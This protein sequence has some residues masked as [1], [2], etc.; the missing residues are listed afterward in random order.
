MKSV[1]KKR[2][3]WSQ[4]E[5][6]CVGKMLR[7]DVL[8][9][10]EKGIKRLLV[11]F[12]FQLCAA[13]HHSTLTRKEEFWAAEKWTFDRFSVIYGFSSPSFDFVWKERFLISWKDSTLFLYAFSICMWKRW[14]LKSASILHTKQKLK[15]FEFWEAIDLNNKK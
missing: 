7:V 12:D 11:C 3:C 8:R 14:R 1:R 6:F 15:S 4:L 10:N 2:N 13:W 9:T 5:R